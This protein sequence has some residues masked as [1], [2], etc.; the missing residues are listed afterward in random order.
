[1][2]AYQ[3]GKICSGQDGA[4]CGEMLF[5]FSTRG[6]CT[7]YEL[8]QLGKSAELSPI[9]EFMLDRSDE[10][11]PHS[12]AVFFG[13]EYYAEGD[14]FP[15][16]YSNIYNNYKNAED[17][18]L[19][20]LCVYRIIREGEVFFSKLVQLIE[21]GFTADRSLWRSGAG[22]DV[23]PYGN[24]IADTASGKLYAFVM[25]DAEESTRYFEFDMP[26]VRAGNICDRFGVPRAVLG[27]DDII[28]SFDAPY[29]NFIQG[30]AC[31]DGLIYSLEGFGE[32]IHPMVRVIDT[33]RR[34]QI[35]CEDLY[36]MGLQIESEFIDFLGDMI[37]YSDAHGN[38]FEL[39]DIPKK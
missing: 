35:F 21:I 2:K 23:R 4:I 8:S 38:L 1:M 29:H 10:I 30:A 17:Q 28:S 20:V 3:I 5:R 27:R 36:E 34:E 39:A 18:L 16:L 6:A 22:D 19:G 24:F 7:V 31:R 37:V 33:E 32:K 26:P 12:N 9:A 25:R 14:E 11:A 15:L 13:S